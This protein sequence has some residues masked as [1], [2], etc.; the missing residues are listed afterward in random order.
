MFITAGPST[1]LSTFLKVC[2]KVSLSFFRFS[3]LN[4]L[5][6]VIINFLLLS[7]FEGGIAVAGMK[8]VGTWPGVLND[9][10]SV[11]QFGPNAPRRRN[12]TTGISFFSLSWQWNTPTH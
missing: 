11:R 1:K 2:V 6:V 7:A 9:S 10:S 4:V 8:A 3:F 5:V 12:V